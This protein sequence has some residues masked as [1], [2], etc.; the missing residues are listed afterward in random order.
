MAK[1]LLVEDDE[2]VAEAVID[3][4][5]IAHHTVEWVVDGNEGIDRLKLY[6]YDLAILDWQLPSMQGID[7]CRNHRSGGGAVPILML[8]GRS[9]VL[10]KE[11]GFNSGADD[12]LTK[13]FE[14]RELLARVR[15]LLRRPAAV[16]SQIIVLGEL[17]LN[18]RECN[19]RK[20]TQVIALQPREFAL[21]EFLM[22]H[23]N[24]VFSIQ[25]LLS[26]LWSSESEASDEAVRQCILRL[27]KKSM[28]MMGKV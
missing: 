20:G 4:L 27:R 26:R 9:K 21:I 14:I 11:E 15:A 8:T 3:S 17:V 1:I 5:K 2:K 25:A 12:Y 24:E 16:Q 10:D 23:P 19:L 28:R 7:V 13:P 6:S 22:R 18:T